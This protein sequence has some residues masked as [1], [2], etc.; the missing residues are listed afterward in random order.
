M[1]NYTPEAIRGLRGTQ[2]Q[3]VFADIIGVTIAALSRWENGKSI[4][5]GKAIIRKLDEVALKV[6]EEN[7]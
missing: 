7:L 5:R 1:T 3:A 4:P 2:S 6:K